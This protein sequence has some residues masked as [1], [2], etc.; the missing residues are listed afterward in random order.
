MNLDNIPKSFCIL[1]WIH[2]YIDPDGT[3]KPCCMA[4][5][6]DMGNLHQ[7]PNIREIYNNDRFKE[8][9][10]K[11]LRQE[12]LP[13]ECRVCRNNESIGASFRNHSLK[14]WED[15]LQS[16]QIKDDGTAEYA[17]SYIDYRL[18][19][20]CNFKCITCSPGLSSSIA[21]EQVVVFGEVLHRN[22]LIEKAHINLDP[23]VLNEFYDIAH[24]IKKIYFAGG[25]PLI[26]DY[27]Y[28]I[29]EYLIKTQ[30]PVKLLY[31]TNFSE[32]AY[33]N[34]DIFDLWSK[35]NGQI[36]VG[37]SVDGYGPVGE[38]IRYG[39]DT[40]KFE[41]N[42]ALAK[43]K[44]IS[45]V[46]FTFHITFGLANYPFI[47]DTVKWLLNLELTNNPIL[48]NPV[49]G[50]LAYSIQIMNTEQIQQAQALITE[51]IRQFNQSTEYAKFSNQSSTLYSSFYK[52]M[53]DAKEQSIDKGSIKEELEKIIKLDRHRH[54]NAVVTLPHLYEIWKQ[55]YDQ[56][57]HNQ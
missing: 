25:E 22:K 42:V 39:F 36:D 29:L 35:I 17:P 30:Q 10:L 4:E 46:E 44:S 31:N 2:T 55:H 54:T 1:P 11:L 28:E 47:I 40:K 15:T 9:R 19:N 20:K 26:M 27:H 52:F 38:Y 41:Q 3:V 43:L 12:Q 8:F 51:Q 45:N 48:F 50:P 37:I 57:T 53:M 56:N 23:I 34:H 13:D 33:K 21:K 5:N 32:L 16:L 14:E 7:T 24:N 18:S 49:Y 6:A